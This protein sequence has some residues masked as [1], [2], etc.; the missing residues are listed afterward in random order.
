MKQYHIEY[1]MQIRGYE[2]LEW[3]NESSE[4]EVPRCIKR[5]TR[6]EFNILINLL[7]KD[8]K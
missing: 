7:L 6:D 1:N 4:F 2:L 3:A 8:N 5:F